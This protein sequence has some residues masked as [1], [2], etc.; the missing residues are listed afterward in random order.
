MTKKITG[1][2]VLVICSFI[3]HSQSLFITDTD[4]QP[5]ADV[6]LFSDD[7]KISAITNNA[8]IVDVSKFK[9][10]ASITILHNGFATVV[11]T[12]KTLETKKFRIYLYEKTETLNAVV[13][14]ANKFDEKAKY[15][16][17]QV[18]TLNK[19]ELSFVNQQTSADVLQA[20]GNVLVQKS[21]QGGGSP[22]IR[23][24]ETNKV[25]IVI[26][27]VRMNN[28]IYRGG[29][30]QNVVTLDNA[31]MEKVEVVFG[32][33]SVIYGSDAL[34]GVMNFYT[35]NPML[36]DTDSVLVKANA[37]VR[38]NT[39][40]QGQTYHADLSLGKKRFGSFTSFTFSDFG[41]LKQGNNRNPFYGDWGKRL[42]YVDRIDG[43]DSAVSNTNSNVQVGSA[44]SQYDIL[45][46]FIYKQN[47]NVQHTLNFQYS[48]SSNVPRYDRLT[49]VRN[50]N[51]RYAEWYYGPQNRLLTSYAL[52]LSKKTALYDNARITAA[53]Q[54]IEE[55]RYDRSFNNVNLNQ[56]IEQLDIFSLNADFSKR[57]VKNEL[58]YGAD[59]WLNNVN[60]TASKV[61]INT[62]ETLPL[63]TRYPDGGS[64]MSN[65][66]AYASHILKI[67]ERLTLNDGIR[68]SY[69][70][71]NS[72]FIDKSFFPFPF[73][74]VTQNN[75]AVNGNAGIIYRPTSDWKLS[76]LASSG[77]RAPNVDDLS[78]VFESSPGNIIVPNPNL[79]PEYTYNLDLGITR[80]FNDKITVSATGFYTWYRNAIT[81]LPSTFNGQDSLFF[82]GRNSKVYMSNNANSAY[83]YG[84]N[85][86]VNAALTSNFSINHSTNYTYGR[87]TSEGT[88]VPLDHIAPVFGKTGFVYQQLKFRGE[89]F[90]MYNGAKK[91]ADY[92]PF[93]EDNQA[94]SADPING[95]MPA[96]MTLNIRTGYQI[97]KTLQVLFAVENITDLNYR[98][99]ASNISA[100]GRN[101][102]FTLKGTL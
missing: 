11:T 30:L 93:G 9:N 99:F 8:G 27:G 42:W 89:F 68:A 28:A 66:A 12:Y 47:K 54:N 95:Y 35:K 45:Q 33:G 57:W 69:V 53:Y 87:L 6:Q 18:Q 84:V 43:K 92:N 65:V 25:L 64:T 88:E 86:N 39:I 70:S 40:N 98:V 77:F 32:P 85:F 82:D 74:S 73:N 91:T 23:G 34:G 16:A 10:C 72:T 52:E 20:S 46:K 61:N 63:D 80:S 79:K 44:Y 31:A 14:A 22:I 83:I 97:N 13:V 7:N 50:G 49:Q 76:L 90:A 75:F 48:T 100:A 102:V 94:F 38:Y 59:G 15:V 24:F 29:H 3:S 55:S 51:P 67:N 62:K 36:S 17:Q 60:S 37:Y 78:K 4:L 19:K 1:L 21:Q 71:L 5:I 101:F 2:F 56:R 81:T 96:W 26:D 41:D 58:Y